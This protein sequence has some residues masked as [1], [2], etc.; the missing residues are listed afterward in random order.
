MQQ[1]ILRRTSFGG[2]TSS[3]RRSS[4][5]SKDIQAIQMALMKQHLSTEAMSALLTRPFVLALLPP[6]FDIVAWKFTIVFFSLQLIFHWVLPH[7]T[8][9]L[10]RSSG[11]VRKS[12]NGFSSCLL[13]CLLYVMGSGLGMYRH[14]LV[15]IHFSS[16][17]MCLA[18]VCVATFIFMMITYRCGDYYNVTT[19][20]EFCF[21]VELNPSV[22]DIDIK[23]FVRSRVTLVLWPLFI[24]SALY[25]QRNMYG[26]M[27][28][29]LI[30]CSFVQ[31]VYIIKYH[32]TEY[33]ALNSLD[34]KCANCGFYKLWSD[35][36]LFPVLYCS[37]IAVIA[38]TQK[39]ISLIT[40]C[41]L[42]VAAIFL[43]CLTTVIDKQKYEFRRSKGVIKI[44]GVDPFFITAK[45]KND[46][47]DTSA[48]LLLGSGYWSISR[49]PNYI[50]EAATFAVF[51]AFQG[52]A[53]LASHLPAIFIAGFLFVRLW[54]DEMRCLA[55]Y[56]QCWIQYCNKVP[57][58][59]LP[60][61][62]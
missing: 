52:P 22:L 12:V 14:D 51:S 38:Q 11:D 6:L 15:F 26:K 7:D 33:L 43:I 9:Y 25:Y 29:G 57:F 37:P 35:M 46:H 42:T 17:I 48:N 13:L 10:L 20:S 3:L 28:R 36:V 41:V 45:Y 27:T 47:G 62:Y 50:C 19:I 21:G 30:G 49:H 18:I 34:Y 32:W 8:V 61:I 53:T 55:K 56:G 2:S 54:N 23:H 16:I 31:M 39:S 58:R 59:I 24:I 40:C 44:H 5:S 4:I 60:G 1:R